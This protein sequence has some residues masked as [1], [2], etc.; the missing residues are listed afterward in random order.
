MVTSPPGEGLYNKL[1]FS[2][3]MGDK[4]TVT[5]AS[6]GI[7]QRV[8]AVKVHYCLFGARTSATVV[9][10]WVVTLSMVEPLQIEGD[11]ILVADSG[12]PKAAAAASGGK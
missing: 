3:G 5:V 6:K 1:D 11:A 7:K 8:H 10:G 9:N 12:P 4:A 2:T